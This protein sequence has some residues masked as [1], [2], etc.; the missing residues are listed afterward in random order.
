[1]PS[2]RLSQPSPSTC[3]RLTSWV[4]R[5][6]VRASRQLVTRVIP[7]PTHIP[8]LSCTCWGRPWVGGGTVWMEPSISIPKPRLCAPLWLSGAEVGMEMK[9]AKEV[10]TSSPTQRPTVGLNRSWVSRTWVSN[11]MKKATDIP[12]PRPVGLLV[13]LVLFLL[14]LSSSSR[15]LE[16]TSDA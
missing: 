11:W 15:Y 2:P 16:M 9:D 13:L 12:L 1:M 10:E 8:A 3:W 4:K 7:R 6:L 14:V 5:G